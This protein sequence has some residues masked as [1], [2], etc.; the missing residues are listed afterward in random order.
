MKLLELDWRETTMPGGSGPVA[1]ALLPRQ[2]D[3]A[4]RAYVRFPPGWSRPGPGH[5][6][7]AE[8]FVVLEGELG[9]NGLTW[10]A[11]DY[12]LVPAGCPRRGMH[13]ASG[14]LVLA[15]FSAAPRWIPG[16]P[17][18]PAEPAPLIAARAPAR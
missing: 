15:R 2:P 7:E 10:R 13:T 12:A 5:Y 9:L 11:G 18:P 8:E 16:S 1:L 4:F 6:A 3:N 17:N 14:C